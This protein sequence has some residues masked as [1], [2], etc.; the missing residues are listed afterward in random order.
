MDWSWNGDDLTRARATA[1][2]TPRPRLIQV[3]S[4]SRAPGAIS[5]LLLPLPLSSS[6]AAFCFP[7]NSLHRRQPGKSQPRSDAQRPKAPNW[8]GL[9]ISLGHPLWA[10]TGTGSDICCCAVP[11]YLL[12]NAH[13]FPCWAWP[14]LALVR[15]N[16]G[17]R[18][19]GLST[20][21]IS[22]IP[23]CFFLLFLLI[24]R[25][26][27]SSSWTLLLGQENVR[28]P[29]YLNPPCV[30]SLSKKK[31]TEFSKKKV[32]STIVIVGFFFSNNNTIYLTPEL[33]KPSKLPLCFGLE[34]FRPFF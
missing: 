20:V 21:P 16:L 24:F 31:S 33:S 30:I 8:E 18:H 1:T 23:A 32:Y 11:I 10:G 34:W 22:R 17:F 14:G 3:T 15:C 27:V 26:P 12:G 4:W 13:R 9:L 6:A 28:G 2:D 7:S 19:R 5:A 25:I 29:N